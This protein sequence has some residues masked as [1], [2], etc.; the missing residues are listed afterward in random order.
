VQV[1]ARIAQGVRASGQALR[2]KD[3]P[4]REL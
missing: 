2:Q 4:E 3:A 1:Y